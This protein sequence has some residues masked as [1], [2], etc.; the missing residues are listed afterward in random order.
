MFYFIGTSCFLEGG[1][2]CWLHV[3]SGFG[4]GLWGEVHVH[5]VWGG[6]TRGNYRHN[7]GE[8]SERYPNPAPGFQLPG[9]DP[10][11]SG[12]QNETQVA[13]SHFALVSIQMNVRDAFRVA[14]PPWRDPPCFW[15]SNLKPRNRSC[16]G[17]IYPP[18]SNPGAGFGCLSEPSHLA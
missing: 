3:K 2:T 15:V 7:P 10:P 8:G 16:F 14:L 4:D 5:F 9:R 13:E 12:F 11:L 1:S 18:P 6:S 17:G